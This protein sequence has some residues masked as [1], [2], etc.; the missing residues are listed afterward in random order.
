[1]S[2]ANTPSGT[3]DLQ[4]KQVPLGPA[5]FMIF[6]IGAL[7]TSVSLVLM[8]FMLTG[9]QSELAR[10]ALDERLIPWVEQS[11][12]SVS[13]KSQILADLNGLVTDLKADRIQDRQLMRIRQVVENPILQWG[14]IQQLESLIE[15]STLEPLEKTSSEK[16]LDRLL[17][18]IAEGQLSMQQFEYIL[19]PVALKDN[20]SA[21]LTAQP[22]IEPKA[23]REFLTR[24]KQVNDSYKISD[25]PFVKSP[26]QV[27]HLM[28]DTALT[29]P[30]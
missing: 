7:V 23:I 21:L 22:N 3:N 5:C 2:Q 26:A 24:T 15:Q 30:K 16:E 25:E 18:C 17:R 10:K 20:R 1:M 9:S 14:V 19:Q 13:D 12:L 8:A 28:L 29:L 11:P 6:I 27:F 4:E